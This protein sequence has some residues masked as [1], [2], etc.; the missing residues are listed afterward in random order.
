VTVKYLD[1][2][3][4]VV[5]VDRSAGDVEAR[6]QQTFTGLTPVDPSEIPKIVSAEASVVSLSMTH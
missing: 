4:D 6:E 2:D 1:S 5:E 3:G